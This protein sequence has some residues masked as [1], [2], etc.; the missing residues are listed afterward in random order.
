VATTPPTIVSF[1]QSGTNFASNTSKVT[2]GVSV[3]AGDL[4]VVGVLAKSNSSFGTGTTDTQGNTYATGAAFVVTASRCAA[5]YAWATAGSTGSIDITSNVNAASA[6]GMMVWVLR[7]HNGLGADASR[8]QADLTPSHTITTLGDNSVL[9]VL[10]GD[11]ESNDGASRTWTSING[12]TGFERL[13]QRDTTA[14][15]V[16]YAN[17][18]ADVGPAGS[19]TFGMGAPA[20]QDYS[21]VGIEVKGITSTAAPDV[22]AARFGS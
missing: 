3:Q 14:V 10:N 13:Y 19:K 6:W 15:Y 17:E 7:A 12:S 18:Y 2:S 21:L 8:Q 16:F 11:F 22:V 4:I 1:S 20:G 9:L 5:G